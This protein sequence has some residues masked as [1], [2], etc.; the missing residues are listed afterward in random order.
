MQGALGLVGGDQLVDQ[1]GQ[2]FGVALAGHGGHHVTLGVDHRQGRPGLGRV[3]L[4]HV[5]LRV[6]EHGVVHAVP[7]DGRGQRGRVLLV[8]ELRRV[9]ADDDEHVAVLLLQRAQLVEHVQAVDAAEGPKIEQN[10]LAAK[11][12]ERQLL[13][14]GVQ[15]L[16]TPQ[17]GGTYT[18][19]VPMPASL[20]RRAGSAAVTRMTGDRGGSS[21]VLAAPPSLRSRRFAAYARTSAASRIRPTVSVFIGAGKPGWSTRIAAR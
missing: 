18:R 6:V 21:L 5:Q 14:A 16:P 19:C 10:D 15:P 4:P 8:L 7:L 2:P 17:L 1:P 11:V 9:H 13:P 12:G 3:L 20:P